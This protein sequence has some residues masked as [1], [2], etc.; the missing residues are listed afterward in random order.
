M[1]AQG[2]GNQDDQE[3]PEVIKNNQAY[4]S[5]Y[6]VN[7]LK[8]SACNNCFFFLTDPTE[9]RL[10]RVSVGVDQ[11]QKDHLIRLRLLDLWSVYC[12]R[13]QS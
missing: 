7:I 1:Y 6:I 11:Y 5:G 13:A 8:K 9:V 2:A 3:T 12:L 4:I 10:E